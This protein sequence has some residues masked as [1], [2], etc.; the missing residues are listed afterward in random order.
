VVSAGVFA[1]GWP[2]SGERKIPI[3]PG[4]KQQFLFFYNILFFNIKMKS[5]ETRTAEKAVSGFFGDKTGE[6]TGRKK[7][8]SSSVFS[9]K[10]FVPHFLSNYNRVLNYW[11]RPCFRSDEISGGIIPSPKDTC[12]STSRGIR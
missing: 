8:T 6:K 12:N 11:H 10:D 4:Q 1:Q 5:T 3:C 7:G 2:P 9:A